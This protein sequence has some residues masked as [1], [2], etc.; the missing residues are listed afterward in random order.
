MNNPFIEAFRPDSADDAQI[1][2]QLQSVEGGQ[3]NAHETGEKKEKASEDSIAKRIEAHQK[4][5][6]DALARQQKRLAE[7]DVTRKNL[8]DQAKKESIQDRQARQNTQNYSL[9]AITTLSTAGVGFM[10]PAGEIR[11]KATNQEQAV[12]T[13]DQ[14]AD[15]KL[16][17]EAPAKV[18][19]NTEAQVKGGAGQE[20]AKTVEQ[21]AKAQ[22]VRE[23]ATKASGVAE[24]QPRQA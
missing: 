4:E 9:D 1:R 3:K 19:A 23:Q 5:A 11:T 8:V 6:N 2:K 10:T 21:S 20:N 24:N 13:A 14:Q 12:E 7:T 15:K 18:K 17:A 16:A 22:E